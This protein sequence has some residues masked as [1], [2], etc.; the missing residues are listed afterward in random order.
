MRMLTNTFGIMQETNDLTLFHLK[1]PLALV[2]LCSL[3]YGDLCLAD[4]VHT[5]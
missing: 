3:S 2:F 5:F 4:G 1:F